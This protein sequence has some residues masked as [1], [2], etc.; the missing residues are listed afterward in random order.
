MFL[1]NRGGL[2]SRAVALCVL[3]ILGTV[4]ALG[5][6]LIRQNYHDSL[7]R[8]A[9]HAIIHAQTISY[10]AEPAVLLN[11]SDALNRVVQAVAREEDAD[12]AMILGAD[13]QQLAL[14]QRG[15]DFIPE[16]EVDP[17]NAM[18]G[19]CSRKSIRV[20]RTANQLLVVAPIWRDTSDIALDLIDEEVEASDAPIGF[21]CLT[22]SLENI[23]KELANRM[24]S[25]TLVA[26]LVGGIAIGVTLIAIRQ[27]L[28][29]LKNLV[30]TTTA[31]AQGDRTK[32]A[33]ERAIGEIGE[34]ARS[35][36]HMA[37]WLEE[38]HASIERKV[39]QRTAELETKRQEL[40]DEIVERKRAQAG[41]Q[42][43]ER[44]FRDIVENAKEWVWEIDTSGKYTY[45]SPI[46]EEILGYTR[47][48]VLNKH[49]FDLFHPDDREELKQAAFAAFAKKESIREFVNRNLHKNGATVWLLTGGVPILDEKGNFLGYRGA[50][51]DITERKRAEQR[52]REH[53]ALLESKNLELEAQQGQLQAQQRELVETNRA[54]EQAMVVAEAASKAKSEFL[55]N[56]S[57]E[58]R[59]PM[60][61]I[62][63]M[64][65]LALNTDL[66]DTQHE[67]LTTVMK[68]SESLLILLNDILDFSKIEARKLVLETVPFDL[69]TT[70]ES[71]V[72][73]LGQSAVEKGV[74]LICH[75]HPNAPAS[76]RGDPVRL[77]QVLV[78]LTGNAIKF[79]E[80]GEV[81]VSVEEEKREDGQ[82][83]LLFGV[84]D[85]GI[86]IPKER[87]KAIFDSFTQADGATTRKYGGTGLGLSISKQIIDLMN[88]SIWVES[89]EGQ[90]S[91]FHFRVTVPV[92]EAA[93]A[94]ADDA[95]PDASD[96]SLT[97]RDKRVLIV[98][99]NA[100]NRR[101]LEDMLGRWECLTES[102]CDG[103][104]A[105]ELLGNAV[106]QSQLFD[107]VVLDV[108]M[109]EMDGFQVEREI[110]G[111]SQYGKPEIVFLSSGSSKNDGADQEVSSRNTFLTK[112]IKQS[113]L[114]DTL[115][116]LFSRDRVS[117]HRRSLERRA[118]AV[119]RRQ[120]RAR[121]LLVEDNLV[122][123]EVASG[124]LNNANHD[125]TMAEHGRI[126]LELLEQKS[127][128]L[129]FMDM[130]MPEMDGFEA[131]RR[132]RADRRWRNLPVI[133]MTAHAL[134]GDRER[135]IAAGMDD[136][137][138]KP[139][140]AEELL[141]MVDT[142]MS[143][144]ATPD[145]SV[146]SLGAPPESSSDSV[147][148]P[149]RPLD[150]QKALESLGDDRELFDEALATFLENIPQA[151]DAIQS[152]ISEADSAR[153]Q[154]AA[155]SLKGAASN[156]YAEP[157]RSVAQQ[158]EQLGQEGQFQAAVTMLEELQAS[159]DRLREFVPTLK[160]AG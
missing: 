133:A 135:C 147:S 114:L 104:A 46:V 131:T 21:V 39:A 66:T 145:K 157:T 73:L 6:A 65:E 1:I 74:E 154:M 87:Q 48:E 25:S 49:F 15:S 77:R 35:F 112:P 69:V 94:L 36:N 58:I 107:L 28:R 56:M 156:I 132:I 159:L 115:L 54:L 18:K 26:V 24:Q 7:V 148:V 55:A 22:Y 106:A 17:R 142:W 67:Y 100:T 138:A 128:D 19:P 88:G 98:D 37:K 31:I 117:A 51:V 137:I 45:V 155:H 59:T 72:D 60:N 119:D 50:D 40:E 143:A 53:A 101:V 80:Q 4:G 2:K 68:C 12:R 125:V 141:R 85:T 84:R 41:L 83:T 158:L 10:S 44:R 5:T 82:S 122:N 91:V 111:G 62:I 136:Y 86:G 139:V 52:L 70:V 76:V 102:A 20:Q 38:S 16:V 121:I 61:G 108:H 27:L 149:E 63:G 116:T 130:Q 134:E 153:L 8:M 113:V 33:S 90:G 126:A 11:D 43:K 92:S 9:D 29:P 124:I 144:A 118:S 30:Q 89:E 95:D 64:T 75:V 123:R 81:V 146:G 23:H 78:N 152:A 103:A 71:V 32:R 127:F 3:M 129:I 99:D 110:R 151:L 97:L 160:G 34:L 105:L 57:H 13:G 150:L 120:Y 14:F 96:P 42:E 47:E 140:K 79:T 93:S 109:P